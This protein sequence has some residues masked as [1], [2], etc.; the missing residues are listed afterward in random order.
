MPDDAC[1]MP[2]TGRSP[3]W[4]HNVW[5]KGRAATYLMWGGILM[6]FSCQIKKK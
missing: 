4:L 1:I 5:I 2:D 6:S 3:A